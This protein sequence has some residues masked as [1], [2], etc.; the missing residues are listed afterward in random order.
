[1]T[2]SVYLKSFGCQMNALD[3]ELAIGELLGRGWR[4]AED[5]A[6]ADLIL[7]NTCS[8]RQHA[9]DKVWSHLGMLA[10][11]KAKH[12]GLL[13]GVMG[14]MAERA[15]REILDRMPHVDFVTGPNRFRALPDI[16][17]RVAEGERVLETG[18]AD[19]EF[20]AP[21]HVAARPNRFQAY[22]AVMRG[23]DHYCSYCIVP[24]TRGPEASRRPAEILEEARA[25][26][27]DGVVEITLLGQNI[28][29]YGKKFRDGTSL[30]T[31][32]RALEDV[33]GLRRVRFI[34]SHPA[35]LTDDILR[36]MA[37]CPRACPYLHL[38][39]QSGANRILD[40]MKRRYTR[41]GFLALVA[42]AREVVPGLAV[43]SDIIVGFPTETEA[44]FEE[45]V[46]LAETARF[47]M[48]YVFKYSPRPGTKAAGGLP[49]DVPM[50]TKKRR[51]NALLAVVERIMNEKNRKRLGSVE[52]VLVEGTSKLDPARVTGRARDNRIVVF[53]GS[54]DLAGKY[55][56]V[57][58]TGATS[59]V[60][61]GTPEFAASSL[62]DKF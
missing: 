37:E 59:F 43:A 47:T 34:T 21:R 50:E 52:E 31:L 7:F 55:V 62:K 3:G 57:R 44:D 13:I 32:L 42:R 26:A 49:D 35:D 23:C 36:A 10:R 18:P 6:S 39:A 19:R 16:L 60:L 9:E 61:V 45:S 20:T 51:N 8:V 38:P 4:R 14:C 12:P 22:I 54:E 41:E 56:N 5:I 15:G 53:S 24:F 46:S 28:D 1:M 11:R 29:S 58:I 40:L 25:L 2:A 48:A 30:A 17:A 33:P 27:A